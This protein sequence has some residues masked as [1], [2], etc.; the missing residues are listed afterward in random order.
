VSDIWKDNVK[1][2]LIIGGTGF[3]GK[4]LSRE[5]VRQGYKT[6]VISLHKVIETE[7]ID[8]VNYLTSDVTNCDELK[9]ILEDQPFTHVVNLG[10]YVN[11]AKFKSGGRDILDTHYLGVENL[12]EVLDWGILKSFVQVGSSDEY[13]DTAAPQCENN[14][15]EPI[16]PYSMGKLAA[17]QL[18]QM[19]NRT[20]G[21]PVVILRLFLVYGPGQNNQRFLPQIIE[22]CLNGESF[23]SSHGQQLRDFCYIED[24]VNGIILALE[25]PDVVGHVINLASGEPVKIRTVIE[26]VVQI[27]GSGMPEYGNVPYRVGENMALYADITKAKKILNWQPKTSL[28]DGLA[29]TIKSYMND[30]E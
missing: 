14:K 1:K 4:H 17:G 18:L 23:S 15:E 24:V 8:G 10:G 28:S 19:L 2:L 7:S 6:S 26:K 12:I 30:N 21:F 9:N 16:S 22:G 5:A 11:H 25:N 29:I 20:E 27:I 13:G 3:I